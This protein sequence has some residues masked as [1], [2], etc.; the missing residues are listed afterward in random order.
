MAIHL[1]SQSSPESQMFPQRPQFSAFM[2]PCRFEGEVNNLEV[3]G[4][5]PPEIDGTFYR[6]M[7]DPQLPPRIEDDPWFNGDGNISTF[8]IK[9]SHCHF[10]QRYVRT[11][12]FLKE[13]AAQKAL[14]GKYRNRFTDAIE[15]QIRS[16]ANTN[17][18]YFN[19]RL[20]AC[21]EDSPPYSLDPDTLETYGIEDF[22]GQLPSLTF[23]AHP[24]LDQATGDLVCFGYE[25]R[26]DGT[27]DVCYFVVSPEGVVKETVWLVSPVVGM[28]HDF[29][30]T[31]NWVLFPMIPLTC[32]IERLKAGGEH[33]QW[34]PETPFYI[35]VIPRHGATAASAKWFCAPNAF[36]GHIVN[37]YE[38]D[39]GGIIVDLPLTDRN[40]FF[41]WPDAKGHAP[42]PRTIQAR[43][44]R[45]T[46]DPR[47]DTLDLPEPE[48]LVKED[49]EFPRI[50]DRVSMKKHTKCFFDK[51]DP[52]LGTDFAVVMA[53]VGGGHPLYNS[54]GILDYTT[55]AVATYFPGATHMVQEP[56]FI[57]R[58]GDA[59]EGDGWLMVLVNNYATMSSELHIVDTRDTSKAQA[60]VYLPIR[61]RAG[62]HGNWVD[63]KDMKPP[64]LAAKE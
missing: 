17:V 12:K 52:S 47:S 18:L 10:K 45:Y 62:L 2:K 14:F 38:N 31:E 44:V 54:L 63:A 8:R 64:K 27:P 50:D 55:G 58:P 16:T 46:F 6:V 3:K 5:I 23:T 60:V 40:V 15:F 29:A 13:R 61:L 25:A 34:D 24:K 56:V 33:W 51:M 30:V 48:V 11:E 1:K 32:D 28:I 7:P 35:G 26:G 41:W 36:P 22:H 57:S 53:N 4:T 9:D 20:L 19:G 43:L 21:K 42:D 39:A 49:C 37:A 59:P